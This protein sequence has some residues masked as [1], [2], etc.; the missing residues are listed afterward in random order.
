M[1]VKGC[2]STGTL[3]QPRCLPVPVLG[4]Q[5]NKAVLQTDTLPS[6]IPLKCPTC[7]QS[8]CTGLGVFCGTCTWVCSCHTPSHQQEDQRGT[9]GDSGPRSCV[10]L[11]CLLSALKATGAGRPLA[12][13]PPRVPFLGSNVAAWAGTKSSSLWTGARFWEG[14]E[15]EVQGK[16]EFQIFNAKYLSFV[17][18]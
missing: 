3:G 5:G 15:H 14:R 4:T 18:E 6:D 13:R 9:A 17:P 1:T 16:L 10:W 11:Q 12:Q 7:M 2:H 8:K